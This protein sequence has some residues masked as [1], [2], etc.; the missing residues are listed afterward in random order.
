MPS[1]WGIGTLAAGHTLGQVRVPGPYTSSARHSKELYLSISQLD[2][3]RNRHRSLHPWRPSYPS[4]AAIDV[5]RELRYQRYS[6]STGSNWKGRTAER[7]RHQSLNPVLHQV[8]PDCPDEGKRQAHPDRTGEPQ[9][10]I[11]LI[12]RG[13]PH[14]SV[15]EVLVVKTVRLGSPTPFPRGRITAGTR[16]TKVKE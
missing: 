5:V 13:E 14:C 7:P 6:C 15:E 10:R 1:D 4:G 16:S 11:L 9:S 8:W 3:R 2:P 12:R